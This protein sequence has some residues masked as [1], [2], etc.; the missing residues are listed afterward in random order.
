MQ[1]AAAI[2]LMLLPALFLG[3]CA[4]ESEPVYHLLAPTGPT[5]AAGT[6]QVIGLREIALPRYARRAQIAV[7]GEGGAITLSDT[8][9]WAEEPPRAA[10]RLVARTLAGALGQPVVVEPWPGGAAP[11]LLVEVEVDYFIGAIGG[12]LRLSGQIRVRAPSRGGA[13]RIHPF[14]LSEPVGPDGF[15]DLVASHARALARLA[16][17]IAEATRRIDPDIA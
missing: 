16:A 13:S 1:R 14:D 4:G 8:H 12:E 17:I 9:R 10:S 5:P 3:A 7:L 2:L 11:A 15:T 6:G